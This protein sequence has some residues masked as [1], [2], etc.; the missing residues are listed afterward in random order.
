MT[1]QHTVIVGHVG[2]DPEM[3]YTPDGTAV[4]NFS[5]A[6][7]RRWTDKNTN[8]QREKTTWFK[9]TCWRQLAEIAHQYVT[10]GKQV[11]ITGEVDASA[12]LGQDGQP[13]ASLEITARELKLLG[14]REDGGQG[15]SYGGP[16]AEEL[17][18][19]PF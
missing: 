18:D 13:R 4:C 14:K 10:K 15:A 5:V 7:S 8:E 2:R 1:Y 3:R 16:P 6:V 11:L 9:V 19:I 17:Q 12:Y